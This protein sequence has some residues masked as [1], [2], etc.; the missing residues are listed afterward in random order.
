MNHTVLGTIPAEEKKAPLNFT[1][2]W[3]PCS[4]LAGPS[5]IQ[6]W[7]LS[8]PEVRLS[9]ACNLV[10]EKGNITERKKTFLL[11]VHPIYRPR[12]VFLFWK[13]LI[14]PTEFQPDGEEIT[15]LACLDLQ[16]WA[17]SLWVRRVQSIG[18]C[19]QH[20]NVQPPPPLPDVSTFEQQIFWSP[21]EERTVDANDGRE[22]FSMLY[23]I[24]LL[25]FMLPSFSKCC[26]QNFFMFAYENNQTH[27]LVVLSHKNIELQFLFQLQQYVRT[28]SSS[29]EKLYAKYHSS[30]SGSS[31]RRGKDRVWLARG[32]H[33]QLQHSSGSLS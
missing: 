25:F 13:Y 29:P 12:G 7:D 33:E 28:R 21:H 10:L 18:D 3:H 11:S 5:R 30:P 15:F 2:L 19:P 26:S 32:W 22:V 14:S 16:H 27:T 17:Q 8:W 24:W 4:G 6:T 1:T 20:S 31:G 9:F 23:I